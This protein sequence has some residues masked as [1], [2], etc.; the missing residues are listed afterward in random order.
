MTI[1][2]TLNYVAATVLDG[3]GIIIGDDN[4]GLN[5]CDIL[6]WQGTG[7]GTQSI[8]ITHHNNSSGGT[9]SVPAY[10]MVPGNSYIMTVVVNGSP[11]AYT[12]DVSMKV[13]GGAT[14]VI[15]TA[16][17]VP[18]LVMVGRKIG[19]RNYSPNA[20]DSQGIHLT[21]FTADTAATGLTPGTVTATQTSGTTTTV[22][23]TAA[24]GGTGP[25]NYQFQRAPV[26]SGT[27]GSYANIGSNSTAITF[28]DT[29]LTT[30]NTYSYR[31]VV[32]DAASATATSGAVQVTVYAPGF[33]LT[34]SPASMVLAQ[35]QAL[36]LAV[37]ASAIGGYTGTDT[38]SVT[39]LP[40]GVTAAFSPTTITN[41]AGS[42]TLTLTAAGNAITGTLTVNVS[43][44]DGTITATAPVLLEVTPP[45]G[46]VY[47][48]VG[49]ILDTDLVTITRAGTTDQVACIGF[50][51]L[52]G[53]TSPVLR[54]REIAPPAVRWR[55]IDDRTAEALFR[56]PET[57]LAAIV[58]PPGEQGEA[59]SGS[60]G[61]GSIDYRD[62]DAGTQLAPARGSMGSRRPRS[63]SGRNRRGGEPPA[64]PLDA[65]PR[66]AD[67]A[68]R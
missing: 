42:S 23:T 12:I 6:T 32:T 8:H 64:S 43:A 62:G 60:S 18:G 36:T 20:S 63:T 39:G 68:R 19:V 48:V 38:L 26:T 13:V 59:G 3:A 9:S 21:G 55:D 4:S 56:A 7:A 5:F 24:S 25:Y 2:A 50:E 57:S 14:T 67:S 37:T 17:S 27:V 31:V 40:T 58:G 11:G 16:L 66:R 10:T 52:S 65:A 46:V 35:G 47:P 44:T 33:G 15:A 45:N 29:G 28:N 34:T 22:S 54:F 49:N 30:G 53:V 1:T 51:S 61:F 41:G